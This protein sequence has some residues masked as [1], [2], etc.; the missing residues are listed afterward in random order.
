MTIRINEL[1]IR[2]EIGDVRDN[3]PTNKNA[4]PH[5]TE[6]REIIRIVEKNK[7]KNKRER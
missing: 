3:R 1:I 7:P 5:K 2:A 6:M 4:I